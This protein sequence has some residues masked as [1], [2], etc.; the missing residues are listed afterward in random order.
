MRQGLRTSGWVLAAGAI[1]LLFMFWPQSLGGHVAYVK[2]DGHSMDPT[3]HN[4]DLAVVRKQSSYNLGDAV[5]YKIPKGEFG[6]GSLVIHRLVAGNGT[7]GFVTKGDN[8]T[9]RDEWHPRTGDVVGRVIY[10]LPG[11]GTK[12]ATFTKPMYLG[13]LVAGLT[14]LVMVWPSG[15]TT[16]APVA[17]TTPTLSP[18]IEGLVRPARRGR[19]GAGTPSR[20]SR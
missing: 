20:S 1:L 8:R 6:A 4:G 2:V 11:V 10:D 16:P 15:R 12:F 18:G 3:F 9:I 13:G 17:P 14:V 5:A 19:H 7:T